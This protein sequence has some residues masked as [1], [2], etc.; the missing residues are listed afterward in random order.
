MTNNK[1]KTRKELAEIVKK[2]KKQGR[3]IGFTS[4]AFDIL[5]AGHADYLQKAK[6]KCDVLI[7]GVNTDK[8]VKKY[9]DPLRPI[10]NEKDRI[11]LVAALEEVDYVF[12]FNERRNKENI[13]ELKP[14]YYIKA[15]DY[16]IK[17]LTS[18]KYVEKVGGKVLIIP[19]LKGRATT[20]IIEKI[21]KTYGN[22]P[23]TLEYKKSK[24]RNRA[25]FI[26]RDG[27]IN[28]EKYYLHEP[29]KFRLRK[30]IIPQLKRYM[31]EGYKLI[32]ITN[33]PGIGFGYYTVED[34]FRVNKEMLKQL[35]Q[36]G[37]LIDRI[38]YCPHTKAENCDC[39]KPKIGLVKRAEKELN[40]DLKKSIF[41]GNMKSDVEC[42]KRAGCK[43]VLV[44]G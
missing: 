37:I 1:I 33:Q 32:V 38:Y 24:K 43:T 11:K 39:R 26:D 44:K 17:E 21:A 31:K 27:T 25:V 2:L 19:P 22:A 7:V 35:S 5:H 36:H 28:V 4:G 42:G 20:N 6:K 18:K 30:S 23:I 9:K 14:D 16:S 29:E 34:F 8:S 15:G 12:L 10:N 40:L 13:L 41:I 3:K